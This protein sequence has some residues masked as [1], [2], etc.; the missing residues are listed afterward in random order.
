MHQDSELV[1]L[2][3]KGEFAHLAMAVGSETAV[4]NW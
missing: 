1:G 3:A 2:T 4:I